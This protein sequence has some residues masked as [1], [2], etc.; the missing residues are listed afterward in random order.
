[1]KRI[2][3]I[4]VALVAMASGM[5]VM[6]AEKEAYAVYTP[7]DKTLTFYY[8]TQKSTHTGSGVVAYSMPE[9]GNVPGWYGGVSV[10]PQF[11]EVVFTASFK[12]YRPTSTNSWFHGHQALVLITNIKNLNTAEVTDMHDMFND[13]SSLTSLDLSQ[14]DTSKVTDMKYMFYGCSSLTSLD[15][16]SFDTSK[17][18]DMK[19]MFYGCSSLTSLNLSSFDTSSNVTDM[20][21]MFYGCKQLTSL[22]LSHF[23]TSNVTTMCCMFW[24]CSSLTSLDL[25]H[26]DTSKVTDMSSMFSLSYTLTR[27]DLSHFDTSNVTDMGGMFWNCKSLTSLDLSHFD[28]SKV[29]IMYDMFDGCEQLT[30]LDLSNFD[31]SKVTGMHAMFYY[32][33][34]LT[35]LDLSNF[36]TSKVTD[37]DTMFRDCNSLTS[38]D[39]TNF[40]TSNV[41]H[42][43]EMFRDC[44]HLTTIYV[45]NGW[46]TSKVT[47]S[48]QMFKNCTAIKGEQETTYDA[49]HIETAYAHIDGGTDNPGYFSEVKYDLWVGG[50]QVKGGNK[51][52]VLGD[53]K[54]SFAVSEGENVLTLQGASISVTGLDEFG[55]YNRLEDLVIKVTGQ[56]NTIQSSD[57]TALFSNQNVTITGGGRLTIKG[58]IGVSLGGSLLTFTVSGGT[59]LSIEGDTYGVEGTTNR[60]R[61]KFY[62]NMQVEG[63]STVLK[64]KGAT[65]G[66]A[67]INSLTLND[68]L[69]ITEPSGAKFYNHNITDSNGNLISGEWIT[70]QVPPS[71]ITTDIEQVQRINLDAQN[72]EWFTIDGRKLSGKPQKKGIYIQGGKKVIF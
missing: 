21:Y 45:G 53:G 59:L 29:T 23:D 36:D 28:T 32:C 9:D 31:T 38:L 13:C 30:S 55:I 47:Y 4:I 58:K 16:S 67:D 49:D 56:S 63:E 14:F 26:F 2:I 70:I 35:S 64:M 62:D 18:T 68:G 48:Y 27:L 46:T 60:R 6:A 41:T 43:G 57:W 66:C 7:T 72:V 37:M 39:L 44:S 54:V 52:D 71:A 17:V 51:G 10:N 12:D 42:M 50:T 3:T 33:R 1:M 22:D 69:T 8:D 61:D 20:K 11:K 65:G 19:Y 34:S 5:K 40:D 15:L 24:N 25:S